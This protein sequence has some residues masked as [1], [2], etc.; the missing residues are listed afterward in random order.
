MTS[1]VS[2]AFYSRGGVTE[3]LAKAIAEGDVR[4]PAR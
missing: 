2:I 1:K 3:A 4:K